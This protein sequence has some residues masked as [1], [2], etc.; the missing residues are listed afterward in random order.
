[1]WKK[2]TMPP[3]GND[4]IIDGEFFQKSRSLA[5]YV[6]KKHQHQVQRRDSMGDKLYELCY[7]VKYKHDLFFEN[8]GRELGLNEQNFEPLSRAVMSEVLNGNCNFGRVVSIYAFC[9]ALSDY[10]ERN[11]LGNRME[12]IAR[13]VAFTIH[14]HLE[15]FN[16]NGGWVRNLS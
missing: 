6:I 2:L 10:C 7:E 1:M 8:V 3:I 15:W 4:L 14:N 13:T 11:N 9:L 12:C 16:I 5:L